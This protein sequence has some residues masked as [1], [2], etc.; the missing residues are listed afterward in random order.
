MQNELDLHENE[1]F[2]A[3]SRFD[4]EA[5]GITTY[6]LL[7]FVKCYRG[8]AWLPSCYCTGLQIQGSGFESYPG[9]LHCVC[10]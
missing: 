6:W 3:K 2:R 5:K 9:S 10:G 8:K 1:W 7:P 4:T